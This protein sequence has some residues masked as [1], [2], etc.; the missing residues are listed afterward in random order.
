[1][2][3]ELIEYYI[4]LLILQYR[5]QPNAQNTIRALATAAMIFDIARQVE[6]GYDVETAIGV[7]L[8]IIGKY[9]GANRVVT[10]IDFERV[11]FGSISYDATPPV[12][13]V[14]GSISYTEPNP[15]DAQVLR[16]DAVTGSVFSLTDQELRI[17][18]NILRSR[19]ISNFS[20]ADIDAIFFEVFGTQFSFTDNL[21]MTISYG[22]TE[23][24]RRFVNILDAE[25]ILMKPLAVGLNIVIG[26]F[27]FQALGSPFTVPGGFGNP[28][29]TGLND[30][31]IAFIDS[32]GDELRTYRF[33]GVNWSQVGNGLPIAIPQF[34]TARIA[35]LNGT[36]IAWIDNVSNELRAYR[37][38]ETD[39]AQ[40]GMPFA[41]GIQ[42][43]TIDI[44]PIS[45]NTIAFLD[46]TNDEL[47]AYQFDGANWTQLGNGFPL[48]TGAFD[49][50][51]FVDTNT[52]VYFDSSGGGARNLVAYRFDGSNWAQIGNTLNVPGTGIVSMDGLSATDIAFLQDGN[53]QLSIY[54][55]DDT[56][57][58]EISSVDLNSFFIRDIAALSESTLVAADINSNELQAYQQQIVESNVWSQLGTSL[59]IPNAG[60][61]GMSALTTTTVAYIDSDNDQLRTYGF[62][63]SS[64]TQ[65]GNSF[66]LVVSGAPI[67][68]SLTET[69]IAFI[70]SGSGNLRTYRFDGTDWAQIGNT[71]PIST[72]FNSITRLSP[73]TIAFIDSVNTELRR[74]QF[75]GTNWSEIGTALTIPGI[76]RPSLTTFA[77]NQIA[78]IDSS[79]SGI[80]A[81]RFISNAW[82][83]LGNVFTI[84][85]LGI[86]VIESIGAN[87]FVYIDSAG[88][89]LFSLQFD[90]SNWTLI[91]QPLTIPNTGTAA[92]AALSNTDVAFIDSTNEELR[93]YRRT[94]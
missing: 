24:D 76:V 43:L 46:D 61:P 12:L 47:R 62:N 79:I 64:W 19:N 21:N 20:V 51:S 75:D 48:T 90:G 13:G 36:D 14:T 67:I 3:E 17:I 4:N 85:N 68:T 39:W 26:S 15:P 37:F 32:T 87:N 88:E 8:D 6:N 49:L 74:Y 73:T 5:K 31:D 63:G 16:Y 71:L 81:Y 18:I 65:V 33:D 66:G 53:G 45:P 70:D 44:V 41:F 56:D 9:V 2:N 27:S 78:L 11:F 83:P 25:N 86:P 35:R 10:A 50:G 82:T 7:Q 22:F 93:T 57:F 69:D 34:F 30:S 55:F 60:A 89:E 80:Q 23:V 29:M 40:I 1:M 77:G 92:L 72:G 28:S 84:P 54:R 58:V 59:S 94:I 38:D 42:L 91:G 52:V